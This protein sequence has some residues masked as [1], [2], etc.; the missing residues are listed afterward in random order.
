MKTSTIVKNYLAASRG[1][2]HELSVAHFSCCYRKFLGYVS[3]VVNFVGAVDTAAAEFLTDVAIAAT[4]DTAA[5]EFF[6]VA[7]AGVT[8]HSR[9]RLFDSDR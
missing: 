9:G 5:A 2:Y 1:A 3:L 4:L 6:T 8:L 7:A